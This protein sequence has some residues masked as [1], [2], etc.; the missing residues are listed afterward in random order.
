MLVSPPAVVPP[1]KLLVLRINRGGVLA[2]IVRRTPA[3]ESPAS[4]RAKLE[5]DALV[6][7]EVLGLLVAWEE[8]GL[9]GID[10]ED[11]GDE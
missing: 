11:V 4:D 3:L 8:L 2:P 1:P 9:V 10:E 5:N 6:S 7:F